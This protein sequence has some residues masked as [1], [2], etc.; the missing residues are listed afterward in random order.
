MTQSVQSRQLMKVKL[1]RGGGL[2][3]L[4]EGIRLPKVQEESAYLQRLSK[5][6]ESTILTRALR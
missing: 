5:I 6:I 1:A 4:D 2:Q 3:S